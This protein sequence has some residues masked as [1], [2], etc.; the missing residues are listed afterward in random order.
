[1][2][3]AAVFC[4]QNLLPS[5]PPCKNN[6]LNQRVG[7]LICTHTTNL[8]DNTF[9]SQ[10]RLTVYLRS[11]VE[12]LPKPVMPKLLPKN[13][14]LLSALIAS[15]PCAHADVTVYAAASMTNAIDDINQ[16]YAQTYP[17]AARVKTSYAASS[18]LAKQIEQGA[19][20]DVFISADT[21]WMDYLAH[22]N[23]LLPNSVR[24]VLANRLVLI[25]PNQQPPKTPIRLTKAFDIARAFDGRLC[26]G[27]TQ[28]VPVGRYAKQALTRLGWW[29]T[30]QPRL[31][32]ADDVRAA[33][34]FVNRGECGL[35]IVY[36]TD[37]RIA[38]NVH[39]VATLPTNLHT[40]IIYPMALVQPQ[41]AAKPD[42]ETVRYYQFLQSPT[43]KAVYRKYGFSVL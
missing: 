25:A 32:E 38:S 34:N 10:S 5:Q 8:F 19:P 14:A 26:T 4:A 27:H 15:L 21:A 30:L 23:R 16:R 41:G 22:K 29:Q 7:V 40:P 13:I 3:L 17:K 2:K 20:A 36:A 28:S 39:V 33:L 9:Y 6:Y 18:T 1:M 24:Q 31:V 37:A 42:A 11:H 35:G 12:H 43:A